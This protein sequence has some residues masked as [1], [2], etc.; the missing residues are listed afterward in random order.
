MSDLDKQRPI[1][2]SLDTSDS[3][4]LGESTNDAINA[5]E[6]PHAAFS[7]TT[8]FLG[9]YFAALAPAVLRRRDGWKQG[10]AEYTSEISEKLRDLA[11]HMDSQ[12]HADVASKISE[13]RDLVLQPITEEVVQ[14]VKVKHDELRDY[15]R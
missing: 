10:V 11:T 7:L 13:I 2:K 15:V 12:G 4:K 8:H 5:C 9:S 6:T 1:T 3:V 14:A